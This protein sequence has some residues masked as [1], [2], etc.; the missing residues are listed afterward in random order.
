MT[1]PLSRIAG[2]PQPVAEQLTRCGLGSTREL[3]SL[4]AFEV[5][6]I[7]S[8]L[9]TETVAL[10]MQVAA[11]AAA[12]RRKTALQLIGRSKDSSAGTNVSS[13]VPQRISTGMEEVDTALLGGLRYGTLSEVVGPNGV[14]KTQLILQLCASAGRYGNVLY[15]GGF[16]DSEV[17]NL[18]S[19]KK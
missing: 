9:P 10:A 5:R 16:H 2:I 4:S 13:A 8:V 15:F 12:P 6:E 3:L 17:T 7:V 14:G 18:E 19:S 11:R 1:T